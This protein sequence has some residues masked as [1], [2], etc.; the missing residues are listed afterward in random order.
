[1]LAS[2]ALTYSLDGTFTYAAFRHLG[3][4]FP[5]LEKL[6]LDS[7]SDNNFGDECAGSITATL[8]FGIPYTIAPLPRLRHLSIVRLCGFECNMHAREFEAVAKAILEACPALEHLYIR[9]GRMWTGGSTPRPMQP[10][11]TATNCFHLLPLTICSLHLED[12][13]LPSESFSAA[14]LPELRS[15]TLLRCGPRVEGVATALV[16]ACP[17]LYHG[18]KV[19]IRA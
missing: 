16:D 10:L 7:L 14:P 1:M 4:Y 9:H 8:I 5:E 17:K 3:D 12:I 2:L 18:K 13:I 15:L 6:T 19:T 11:P